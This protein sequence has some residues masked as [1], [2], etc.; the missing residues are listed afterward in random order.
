MLNVSFYPCFL[1]SA[2]PVVLPLGQAA[3]NAQLFRVVV[4]AFSG[5]SWEEITRQENIPR[6]SFPV[7][8]TGLPSGYYSVRLDAADQGRYSTLAFSSHGRQ[9]IVAFP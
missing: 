6:T 9:G 1:C 7:T 4:S 2:A 5:S 3:G 8:L